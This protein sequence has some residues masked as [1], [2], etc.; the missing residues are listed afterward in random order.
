MEHFASLER[1]FFDTFSG[2]DVI[3]FCK[4]KMTKVNSL[5][6]CIN[7]YCEWSGQNVNVEKSG[8]FTSKGVHFQFKM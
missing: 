3:L 8:F 7:T 6:R 2:F 1:F 4:A 5:I